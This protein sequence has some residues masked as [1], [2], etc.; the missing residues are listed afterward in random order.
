MKSIG[1]NFPFKRTEEGGII[2]VTKI[3]TEK[4]RANLISFLT[5][6]RGQRVMNNRL[7]SPCYDYLME[8]WDEISQSALTDE[9]KQKLQ[10]FFSEIQVTDI[11]FDFDENTHLLNIKITYT[12]IDLNI[13]DNII[14]AIPTEQ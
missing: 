14:V 9:L 8:Q 1:I 4:I 2:G 7:Y 6:R 5:T 3:D 12:I 10:E 13:Q 11:T